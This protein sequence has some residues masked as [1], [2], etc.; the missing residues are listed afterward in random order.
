MA[1]NNQAAGHQVVGKVV[2]LYGTVKAISPDG[3]IRLLMPNSPIFAD[4]RIVTESDGSASIVFDGAQGNQLDLGRMMNVAIDHDVYGTVMS[5][6]TTDT[7]AEVAQIQQALATGDQ[8]IELEAPAAGG[9]ADAGGTHPIYVVT[10]TGEE[11]L[12]TGGVT[13]TGVTF[14]TTGA[15]EGPVTVATTSP[16]LP[17]GPGV[18]SDHG[19]VTEDASNP[20]L[21]TTGTLTVT[22][23]FGNHYSINTAVAPVASE[24]ALGNINIDSAGHWTYSVANSAVQYLGADDVKVEHF[25][26]QSVDGTTHD[27]EIKINGTNDAPQLT[28]DTFAAND[29]N[30]VKEDVTSTASGNVLTNDI[31]PDGDTLTVTTTDAMAGT[32]GSVTI[33]ADGSYTYTLNN[34]AANVQA[35]KDGQV[36][37]DTFTYS[38]SDGHGGTASA[39]LTIDING[40]NDGPQLTNDTFAANDVNAVKEDVT[41]TASG[42]VLTNDID[43]DG[44]TLTVTTTDAMA[45]TYGSV[46]IA[47]DGSYTYTL[48]NDAANVQAL[49]D[50]Q[51]AHDIFTY[52]V[53]DGHGGTASATL[54]I[55]INGTN[56]GPKLTNDTFA[57]NDVNAVKED[58]TL[59][60]SGNVLTNDIDPDGDTLTV[61]TTDAMAGTYGSVT[62]AADGSYT[63]TLNNDAA[64]VQALKDGQVVHDTFTYSVSDGHGGTASATLTIDINGTNDGS[65][66]TNDTNTVAEDHPAKGNVLTNDSDVDNTLTVASFQV[67]GDS[68]VYT[69][70]ETADIA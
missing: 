10:A 58:V 44:D 35:L 47:A 21:S 5:G 9:P 25:T 17:T 60:A 12:P 49:K 7:T 6:D 13:T 57:A 69:Y 65:K 34:D 43:P 62:I 46:T 56:D 45:G 53:S 64:N 70:G 14:G 54:T 55:D 33:A 48:N 36:V 39:T 30:A 50:G 59:T 67:A 29:V 26:V 41:L 18:G 38:V 32:Y 61:T 1:Q 22:D 23:T 3:A 51:V 19:S 8:P 11:V 66:L 40:T 31:D 63:Y 4:D 24:G 16:V 52:S 37:H 20:T 27:I 28:N 42:N 15:I 68:H 2:I